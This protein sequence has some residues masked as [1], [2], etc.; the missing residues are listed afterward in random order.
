MRMVVSVSGMD[1][2]ACSLVLEDELKKL[3]GIKEV[4]TS[5]ILNKIFIYYDSSLVE[6]SAIKRII[7][8]TGYRTEVTVEEA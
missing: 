2:L 3:K 4:K 5:V 1:C 6:A 8:K 7:D